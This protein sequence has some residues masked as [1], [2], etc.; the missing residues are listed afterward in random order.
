MDINAQKN[1]PY[2]SHVA[3]RNQAVRKKG[4][5][6]R[7]RWETLFVKKG[8]CNNISSFV[9]LIDDFG[10]GW[11]SAALCGIVLSWPAWRLG[12]GHLSSQGLCI[13]QGARVV[14]MDKKGGGWVGMEGEQRVESP[15]DKTGDGLMTLEADAESRLHHDVATSW[16]RRS[17]WRT[18]QNN[19]RKKEH[20]F[21]H[22][23]EKP[24][25]E[26]T[27]AW[28]PAFGA[29]GCSRAGGPGSSSLV[30]D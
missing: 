16:S 22:L 27:L 23:G 29:A 13:E 17:A 1:V 28:R 6:S 7:K 18:V 15:F 5:R 8:S 24:S 26:V 11:Y 2:S 21:L 9:S 19:K 12:G 14:R 4:Q 25:L 20:L 3:W 30:W 10:D